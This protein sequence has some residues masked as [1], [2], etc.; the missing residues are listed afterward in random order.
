RG[1]LVW[2]DVQ[3]WAGFSAAYS[4]LASGPGLELNYTLP[5]GGV[6]SGFPLSLRKSN[7]RFSFRCYRC[8]R[9]GIEDLFLPTRK[10]LFYP[11]FA[12]ARCLRLK[13]D[14]GAWNPLAGVFPEP[15]VVVNLGPV[16]D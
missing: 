14:L 13:T 6:T 5:R 1:F 12:C 7:D 11:G 10:R 15:Q 3:S 16:G 8:G 4:W 2:A 9:Y